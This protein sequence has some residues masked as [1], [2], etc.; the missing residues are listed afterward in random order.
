[1]NASYRFLSIPPM[2]RNH[3]LSVS[4]EKFSILFL[5]PNK[6]FIQLE[7]TNPSTLDFSQWI[8][9]EI[10]EWTRKYRFATSVPHFFFASKWH[11]V[12]EFDGIDH[13]WL[14]IVPVYYRNTHTHTHTRI[15]HVFEFLTTNCEISYDPILTPPTP[16]FVHCI[17]ILYKL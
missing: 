7:E 12:S 9:A 17:S 2:L 10:I 14:F 15:I 3:Q 6:P 16:P 8:P 1:M 4:Y 11:A 13:T 5:Y